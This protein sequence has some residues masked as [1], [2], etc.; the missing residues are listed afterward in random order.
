[1]PRKRHISDEERALFETALGDAL[2]LKATPR[3][4]KKTTLPAAVARPH[5]PPGPDR[6]TPPPRTT[7]ID[8]RTAE[9]LRRGLLE[10]Q[11]RLDLHG[12]SERAAHGALAT[13]LRGAAARGL[14]LILVITGKGAATAEPGD[15][16]FDLAAGRRGILREMTPRWLNEPGLAEL[17]ADI[18]NAHP[19]HGGAGALYVY[20]RKG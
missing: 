3:R 17:V 20:L 9:R 15:R 11:A 10:P 6:K 2:P 4:K 12:L 8:G 19:R 14:R 18:R 5:L 16:P 1:M 7:G 13:F